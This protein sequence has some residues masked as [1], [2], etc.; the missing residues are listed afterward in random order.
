MGLHFKNGVDL[1]NLTPQT[2]VAIQVATECFGAEGEDCLVTSIYRP[3]LF[4]VVGFHGTGNA[5]DIG[6]RKL[7]GTPIDPQKMEKIITEIN[8]RIGRAG[9]GQYDVVNEMGAGSSTY[10]T[11][12]H[13]HIEFDP[14]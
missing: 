4:S 1:L 14:K 2:C 10:W 12:S 11:G 6:A 3:G 13:V 9:G 7:D 5:V 8:K